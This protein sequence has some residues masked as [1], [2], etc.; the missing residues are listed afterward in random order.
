MITLVARLQSRTEENDRVTLAVNP[1]KEPMLIVD[2]TLF[3]VNPVTL[4]GVADNEKSAMPVAA[5]V[6]C[7]W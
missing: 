1:F 4:V 5:I 3:P 6:E 7:N 2:A